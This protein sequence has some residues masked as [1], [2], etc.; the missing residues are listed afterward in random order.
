MRK[1]T[2]LILAI[3]LLLSLGMLPF[4]CGHCSIF[5][6]I[7]TEYYEEKAAQDAMTG[8]DAEAELM[9][10]LLGSAAPSQEK[11]P[12]APTFSWYGLALA[13]SAALGI[14]CLL[15]FA[16]KDLELQPALL[17]AAALG[18]PFGLIGARLIYC[19]ASSGFYL[20]D[21]QNPAAMMRVWEGGLSLTGALACAALAGILA[22]RIC[23]R[24]MGQVLDAL[25]P[26]LLVFAAGARLSEML[27]GAG[28]GPEISFSLPIL[29]QTIRGVPRLN[30]ALLMALTAL[31]I[32]VLLRRGKGARP[33]RQFWLAAFLYGGMLLLLESLRRDGHLLWGFVHAE[34]LFALLIALPA[35]LALARPVRRL[36]LALGF[37]AIL[38]AAIIALEFA[39]DRS[40]IGDGWLYLVYTVLVGLYLAWGFAC[41]KRRIA[42]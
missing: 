30:T 27:I 14:L 22:A 38:A 15:L 21:I 28:F 24:P 42:L 34:Q 20:L 5:P 6:E 32:L 4:L 41:A 3:V 9:R 25:T 11:E 29:T 8:D 17:W 31:A 19:I 40:A 10:L 35:L 16:P 7:V 12:T 18:V 23:R 36:S 33:G 2:S 39:L 13:L 26:G 37:T 1:G